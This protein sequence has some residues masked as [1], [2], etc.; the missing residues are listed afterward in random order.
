MLFLNKKRQFLTFAFFLAF[1]VFS[2][3]RKSNTFDL[4]RY[5]RYYIMWN[6]VTN[7]YTSLYLCFVS[8]GIWEVLK[9]G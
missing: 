4:I 9:D 3:N 7:K 1:L 5:V 8:I 6:I 2:N